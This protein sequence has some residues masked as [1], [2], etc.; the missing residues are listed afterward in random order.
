MQLTYL[1]AAA[2]AAIA[3]KVNFTNLVLY[4]DGP[5]PWHTFP[6]PSGLS[7]ISDAFYPHLW[8]LLQALIP[9]FDS[10]ND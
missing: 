1:G 8:F 5:I 3:I 7:E 6:R 2:F 4:Y 10:H 9:D